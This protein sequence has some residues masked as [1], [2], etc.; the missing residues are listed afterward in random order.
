MSI[1]G[2]FFVGAIFV[3]FGYMAYQGLQVKV[4]LS[5]YSAESKVEALLNCGAAYSQKHNK[6]TS[7]MYALTAFKLAQNN[8]TSQDEVIAALERAKSANWDDN[9]ITGLCIQLL[10]Y[11]DISVAWQLA[12]SGL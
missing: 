1:S 7:V 9:D 3:G 2:K 8:G 10:N 4:P 5:V 12:T 6:K 11:D